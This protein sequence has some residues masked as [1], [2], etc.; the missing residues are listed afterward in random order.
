MSPQASSRRTASAADVIRPPRAET[1]TSRDRHEV[2]HHGAFPARGRAKDIIDKSRSTLC[3]W[4][5][6]RL[7]AMGLVGIMVSLGLYALGVSYPITLGLVAAAF[8]WVPNFGPIFAAIPAILVASGGG[9]SMA[10]YTALLYGVVQTLEGMVLTPILQERAVSLPAA[11]VILTQLI[12]GALF[13]I[14]G[15]LFATPLVAVLLVVVRE[16]YVEEV[17]DDTEETKGEAEKT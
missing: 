5:V 11:F 8:D 17:L 12:M 9:L 4:L 3:W 6:G 7:S 1:M 15:L 14:L 16:L 10:L 2:A 13:G